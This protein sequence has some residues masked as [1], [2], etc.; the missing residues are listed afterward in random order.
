M[1]QDSL[2]RLVGSMGSIPIPTNQQLKVRKAASDTGL[3]T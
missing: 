1:T 2:H 3:I